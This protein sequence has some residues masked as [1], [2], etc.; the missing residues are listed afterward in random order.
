VTFNLLKVLSE[1]VMV[2]N[3]LFSLHW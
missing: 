3:D 1:L 2:S